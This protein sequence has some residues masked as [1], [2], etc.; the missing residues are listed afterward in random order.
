VQDSRDNRLDAFEPWSMT[1]DQ[2]AARM[3][4]DYEKYGTLIRLTGA[5]PE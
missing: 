4:A 5:K 3:R 1:P 2:T